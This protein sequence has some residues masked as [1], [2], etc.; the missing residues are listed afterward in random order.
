MPR[1]IDIEPYEK[2][3]HACML[4]AAEGR[5]LLQ[6]LTSEIPTA[7]VAPVVRCKD[8]KHAQFGKNSFGLYAFCIND[9]SGLTQLKNYEND[10]CSYGERRND[11]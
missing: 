8:C 2:H 9:V 5:R 10:F 1:Y 7:D 6:T 4:Y 3:G 11:A